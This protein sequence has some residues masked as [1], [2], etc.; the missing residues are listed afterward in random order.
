MF[1]AGKIFRFPSAFNSVPGLQSGAIK[2]FVLTGMNLMSVLPSIGTQALKYI[3]H[4]PAQKLALGPMDE[5][6]RVIGKAVIRSGDLNRPKHKNV[7]AGYINF[8]MGRDLKKCTVTVD[9][10]SGYYNVTKGD[11]S[12]IREFLKKI[13]KE[14]GYGA[15][16]ESYKDLPADNRELRITFQK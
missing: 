13:F 5:E 7:R 14:N 1:E 15:G 10:I 3:F 8:D 11:L 6:H 2:P 9:S 4:V 16:H 12:D